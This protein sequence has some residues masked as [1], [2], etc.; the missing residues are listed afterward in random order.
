MNGVRPPYDPFTGSDPHASHGTT[1]G[2]GARD[3]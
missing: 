1:I 3:E 2:L